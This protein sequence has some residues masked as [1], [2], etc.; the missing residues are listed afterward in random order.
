MSLVRPTPKAKLR[1]D[2]AIS[3]F[4][5]DLS[6]EQNAAFCISRDNFRT[7]PPGSPDVMRLI[8]EIDRT[9][10]SLLKGGRCFGPRFTNIL[11]AIQQF[12]ALGDVIVGGSQ[13]ILACGV[14]SLVRMTLLTAVNFSS[15]LDQLSALFMDIGRSAPR[16]ERL[17][18][19]YPRSEALQSHL[20]EYFI[21][22]VQICHKVLKLTKRSSFRQVLAFMSDA[23][24][25]AYKSELEAVSALIKDEVS[26]LMAKEVREQGAGI[27]FL[28]RSAEADAQ[29]QKLDKH[30]QVL[31]A[32]SKY[33][34]ETTWKETKK[35]GIASWFQEVAEYKN[36]KARTDSATLICTGKLGSGKSVLLAN[37]VGDLNLL[38]PPATCPVAYF[39]CRHDIFESLQAQTVIGSLARQL[40]R[41]VPDLTSA[42]EIIRPNKAHFDFSTVLKTLRHTLAP[43]F[44]AY[45]VLDGLDECP[46]PQRRELIQYLRKLQ[47]IFALRVCIA[48]RSDVDGLWTLRPEF[49]INSSVMSVPE[50][51]PEIKQFIKT[52]LIDC[53][54][55]GR[56]DLGD[57]QLCLEIEDAL[58]AGA[59]GMFLWA[60]LQIAS[61]CEARTDEAIR[62]ALVELPRSL[63]ETFSR[64]LER[65]AKGMS[66]QLYQKRIFEFVIAARRPLTTDELREALSVT[67]GHDI[68]D[69]ARLLNN[70]FSTLACCGSLIMVDEENLTV[71]LIHHSVRQFLVGNGEPTGN[72]RMTVTGACQSMRATLFTYLNYG[73]FDTQLSTTVAPQ[74]SAEAAPSKIIQSI[75]APRI[76]R[77][78]ALKLLK[79]RHQPDFD[80]GRYIAEVQKRPTGQ[81]DNRFPFHSY[82][83]SYWIE[84]ASNMAMV[85]TISR[86]MLLKVID[87]KLSC[88][89]SEDEEVQRIAFLAAAEGYL[90]VLVRCL[91]MGVDLEIRHKLLGTTLLFFAAANGHEPCV[92]TLADRGANLEFTD[93]SGRTALS[94]AA[95]LAHHDVVETLLVRGAKVNSFDRLGWGPLMWAYNSGSRAVVKILIEYGADPMSSGSMGDLVE[96]PVSLAIK[97]GDIAF[98]Q[99]LLEARVKLV[100]GNKPAN[101][102]SS[103]LDTAVLHDQAEIIRLLVQH[104]AD[105]IV[106]DGNRSTTMLSTAAQAGRKAAVGA[107]IELGADVNARD[108]SGA[109]PLFH[110][111]RGGYDAIIKLLI[112]SGAHLEA[113][114]GERSPLYEAAIAGHQAATKVLVAAGANKDVKYESQMTALMKLVSKGDTE[115]NLH[116]IKLL[117]ELGFALEA[118]DDL[119]QTPL[120]AAAQQG[121]TAV[122]KMLLDAGANM[123]HQDFRGLTALG[124]AGHNGKA[125]TFKLLLEHGAALNPPP[126]FFERMISQPKIRNLIQKHPEAI[127]DPKLLSLVHQYSSDDD[128]TNA[129]GSIR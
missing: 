106:S 77:N 79:V 12:A 50:E 37:I 38:V 75:D 111:A 15:Y 17:K 23:D 116:T 47:E 72:T 8:E 74:L 128:D 73:V 31:D 6:G 11:H 54:E 55:S 9:A 5:K 46:H 45:F 96:S 30:S 112:N 84:H 120:V 91:D 13:N 42:Y 33:D 88:L 78:L 122:V 10:S 109:T 52:A 40:L 68:W 66:G 83:S 27:K 44:R 82:A 19:L 113:K 7:S 49:F 126:S 103:A 127:T 4:Q 20:C 60:A 39:F 28:V 93:S 121:N 58:V 107:L 22:V 53:I 35:L 63:P 89:S 101:L 129:S 32:C 14:W 90:S 123:E 24:M 65:S 34:H 124:A 2:Q 29:R 118:T 36:W 100:P 64:I 99:A 115:K 18:Q 117:I 59:Q 85:E 76:T 94:W 16:H 25:K 3:D 62:R 61:L 97:H 70:V 69:P 80:I 104:G 56:L 110:A 51:N 114:D 108:S 26:L 57:F 1:L 41:V 125:D 21:V 92:C 86:Q 48:C 98:V 87:R 119:Q 95:G 67:P 71:R 102:L 81:P 105:M 43:D